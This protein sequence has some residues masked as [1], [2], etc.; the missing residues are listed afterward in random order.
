MIPLALSPAWVVA[1][2]VAFAAG[3]YVIHCEHVKGNWKEAQALAQAQIA[4]NAKQALRDVKSK[5]RSDENYQRNISRLRAD[6]KRLR[7]A[8]PVFV[9]VAGS[10]PGSAESACYD[11]AELD[12]ALQRYREGI[13]G[14]L[15]EGAAAVEGLDEAR[16]WAQGRE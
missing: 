1:G 12:A 6:V 13:L 3:A 10:S 11:A 9:P 8:R 15:E 16:S 2:L 7:D 4:S 5:E 14:L